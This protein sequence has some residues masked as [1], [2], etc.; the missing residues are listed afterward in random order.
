MNTI[1]KITIIVML[2]F[3]SASCETLDGIQ[4]SIKA[5]SDK[6]NAAAEATKNKEIKYGYEYV[7]DYTDGTKKRVKK[8]TIVATIITDNYHKG[9]T[10]KFKPI[11]YYTP[12]I[13]NSDNVLI[14]NGRPFKI[15]VTSDTA[16]SS[17]EDSYEGGITVDSSSVVTC[18]EIKKEAIWF[19]HNRLIE[20]FDPN[21]KFQVQFS[22]IKDEKNNIQNFNVKPKK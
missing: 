12:F 4:K 13:C 10:V 20:G 14:Q 19:F 9:F 17:W 22:F 18:G 1:Q 11:G 16:S 8:A 3:I 15:R 7:D 6:L 21:Q 2:A 5:G